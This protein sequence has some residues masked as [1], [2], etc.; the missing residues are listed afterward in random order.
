MKKLCIFFLWF[1]DFYKSIG[2]NS[3]RDFKTE[4]ALSEFNF[5]KGFAPMLDYLWVSFNVKQY[6]HKTFIISNFGIHP[7]FFSLGQIKT[8]HVEGSWFL[9]LNILYRGVSGLPK[10]G[11]ASG[12]ATLRRCPAVPSILPKTWWAITH[13]PLTPLFDRGQFLRC[14]YLHIGKRG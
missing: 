1:I 8:R 13:P 11:W 3:T 12:N 7:N 10:T 14:A 4:I 2:T 6:W 5:I 9:K